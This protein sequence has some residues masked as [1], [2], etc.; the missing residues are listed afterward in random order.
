[1]QNFIEMRKLENNLDELYST[2]KGRIKA[3]EKQGM[4]VSR[5]V[6]TALKNMVYSIKT[7]RGY[8][9]LYEYE[10]DI[11][12]FIPDTKQKYY[13][14]NK[15]LYIR[16]LKIISKRINEKKFSYMFESSIS[17]GNSILECMSNLDEISKLYKIGIPTNLEKILKILEE[18]KSRLKIRSAIM[19][20]KNINII[21]DSCLEE[22]IIDSLT[23][24]DN[25]NKLNQIYTILL[26][27]SYNFSKKINPTI[28]AFLDYIEI[29]E[30]EKYDENLNSII[31]II[32]NPH[33]INQIDPLD[34]NIVELIGEAN[35]NNHD[36]ENMDVIINLL[37]KKFIV[38][39]NW[40]IREAI[41]NNT[42]EMKFSNDFHKQLY[43]K[44]I[45][46]IVFSHDN[47]ENASFQQKIVDMLKD[48][49]STK[50]LE[51][52]LDIYP[53]IDKYNSNDEKYEIIGALT[54]T[55]VKKLIISVNNE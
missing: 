38:S 54:N 3:T 8:K 51:L 34:N 46:N 9:I 49:K 1:M 43:I 32:C 50:S 33:T 44:V 40:F 28:E 15:D 55:K 17:L 22:R 27:N 45:E 26:N 13:E 11:T 4:K 30:N 10:Y 35:L 39:D 42:L 21:N 20:L 41:V 48:I 52:I 2:I 24:I 37:S 16:L 19:L 14:V 6:K 23:K 29:E 53:F 25:E 31:S 5:E 7:Y 18:S 47:L 12:K 36:N